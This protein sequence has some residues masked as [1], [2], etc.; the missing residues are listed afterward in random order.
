MI[1]FKLLS[2]D[3]WRDSENGWYWNNSYLMED[4]IYIEESELTPRKIL[5]FLRT[6]CLNDKSKGKLFIEDVAQGD[7]CFEVCLK[8][9]GE[10]L[11][12]LSAIH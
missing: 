1:K 9:T 7:Y 3:A 4:D 5:R 11:F 2:I 12:A 6:I 10:P 8:S